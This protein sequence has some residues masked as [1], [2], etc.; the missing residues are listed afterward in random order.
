MQIY[1]KK[2]NKSGPHFRRNNMYSCCF[3]VTGFYQEYKREIFLNLTGNYV[4]RLLCC[5]F[6]T[7]R[8]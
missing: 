8:L 3:K 5:H 7:S 1:K 2:N 4:H 6:N